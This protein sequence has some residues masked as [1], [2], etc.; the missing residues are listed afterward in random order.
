M[1]LFWKVSA[2]NIDEPV[3]KISS[4]KESNKWYTVSFI[5]EDPS[6]PQIIEILSFRGGTRK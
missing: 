1:N 3:W 6:F 4:T 2:I 5:E